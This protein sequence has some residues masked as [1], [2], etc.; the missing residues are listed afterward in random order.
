VQQ[1]HPAS[2]AH[3]RHSHIPQLICGVNSTIDIHK[4]TSLTLGVAYNIA[5]D[6]LHGYSATAHFL[7]G[8]GLQSAAYDEIDDWRQS[9]VACTVGASGEP[10]QS[11]S[12]I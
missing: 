2:H 11:C 3:F 6:S 1:P 12:V 8:H 5:A 4:R 9:W 10:E 7:A